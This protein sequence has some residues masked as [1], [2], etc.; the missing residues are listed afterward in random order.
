MASKRTV[1][2]I[3]DTIPSGFVIGRTSGQDGP[4]ELIDLKSLTLAQQA[5]MP[6]GQL[7]KPGGTTSD[8]GFFFQGKPAF[9]N[10]VLATIKP[11]KAIVLPAA[12]LGS[13]FVADTAPLADYTV[14]LLHNGVSCGTVKFAASTGAV[15]VTFAG[16]VTLAIGDTFTIQGPATADAAIQDISFNF[17]A[18]F[19]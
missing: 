16:S 11:T 14:T 15:T 2:G 18:T 12:L 13:Q 9:S 7:S 5:V 8:F 17:A 19:Q 10:M 3:R 4:A 6:N 1:R